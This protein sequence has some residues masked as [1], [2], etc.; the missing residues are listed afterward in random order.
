MTKNKLDRESQALA[1]A[2]KTLTDL[3][4]KDSKTLNESMQWANAILTSESADEDANF[5]TATFEREFVAV[6]SHL[7]S[8]TTS[9]IQL[10]AETVL[11]KVRKVPP[12]AGDERL[13][14]A[15]WPK[16]I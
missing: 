8:A 13:S 4:S 1:L 5:D 3:E 7:G 11:Q 15:L 2:A 9:A 12:A 10:K 6:A 16:S 14:G